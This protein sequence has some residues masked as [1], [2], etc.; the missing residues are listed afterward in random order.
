[1]FEYWYV[2]LAELQARKCLHKFCLTIYVSECVSSLENLGYGVVRGPVEQEVGFP[3]NDQVREQ[4]GDKCVS[5]YNT[6][7]T[8][9][10]S[11][12]F[13]CGSVNELISFL[14]NFFTHCVGEYV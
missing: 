6:V 3:I 10:R 9:L 5:V 2:T 12:W 7:Y 11:W 14:R 13:M 8:V 4:A 1:M